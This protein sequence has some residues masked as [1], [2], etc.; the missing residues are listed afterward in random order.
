VIPLRGRRPLVAITA[1]INQINACIGWID[2][3]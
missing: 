2:N 3:Y 1:T